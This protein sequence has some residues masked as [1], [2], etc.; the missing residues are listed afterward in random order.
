MTDSIPL[1]YEEPSSDA[2][3]ADDKPK[4]W[5]AHPMGGQLVRNDCSLF[6]IWG[7]NPTRAGHIL[8]ARAIQRDAM[9]IVDGL[10]LLA[11]RS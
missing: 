10:R 4:Y 2:L 5:I 3:F 9:Q 8:A 6:N 1:G 11:E 7:W